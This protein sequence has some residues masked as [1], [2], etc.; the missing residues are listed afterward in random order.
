MKMCLKT[1]I[2]LNL[3]NVFPESNGHG[4]LQMFLFLVSTEKF[5]VRNNNQKTKT[6]NSSLVHFALNSFQ[7]FTTIVSKCIDHLPF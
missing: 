1:A 7:V 2:T 3:L 5:T 4:A 6:K